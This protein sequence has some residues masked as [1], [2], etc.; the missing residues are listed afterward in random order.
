MPRAEDG[1][2]PPPPSIRVDRPL[3]NE[4]VAATSV[5]VEGR[6]SGGAGIETVYINGKRAALARPG[7]RETGYS[8]T[9]DMNTA[10]GERAIE[11]VATD[12]RDSGLWYDLLLRGL[13]NQLSGT[14]DF[15]QWQEQTQADP[16]LHDLA[17]DHLR[18][19]ERIE[20]VAINRATGY[21]GTTT[22]RVE[23]E[24]SDGTA[25]VSIRIPVDD[26]RLRPPNLKVE[27]RR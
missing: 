2:C 6:A 7:E 27:A 15:Q 16:A 18:A 14:G 4:R 3:P 10:S 12:D 1:Q 8:A 25:Q 9:L 24:D 5:T 23:R 13:R 17:S 22:A 21:I 26:L 20:V 19:G 11:I